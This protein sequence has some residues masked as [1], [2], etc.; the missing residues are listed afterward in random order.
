LPRT[1]ASVEPVSER[2]SVVGHERPV[3]D[4]TWIG[5]NSDPGTRKVGRRA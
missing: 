4:L 5:D 2:A 1:L 3:D